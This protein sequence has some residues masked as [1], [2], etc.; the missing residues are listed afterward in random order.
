MDTTQTTD[1]AKQLDDII[2]LAD[3]LLKKARLLRH[4]HQEK[5]LG[6]PNLL[7][8]AKS[9]MH[10]RTMELMLIG[11]DGEFDSS[12]FY[13]AVSIAAPG[14]TRREMRY[15]LHRMQ[16]KGCLI[17]AQENS[18]TNLWK[19]ALRQDVCA[20]DAVQDTVKTMSKAV[21]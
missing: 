14:I 18:H 13:Q 3:R 2:K 7:F 11:M 16:K 17:K 20:K 4:L 12:T 21:S 9:D 5:R 15:F 10:Q 8:A 19:K 1:T 6:N